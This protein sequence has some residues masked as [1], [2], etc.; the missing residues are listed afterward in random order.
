V[1]RWARVLA[2]EPPY[3]FVISW[4]ISPTWQLVDDPSHA[5]EVES[6]LCL[7]ARIEPESSWST[8]ISSVTARAGARCV[9]ASGTRVGWP[10]YVQRYVDAV[11]ARHIK[12]LDG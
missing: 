8:V 9:T 6:H 2:F 10:F 11:A 5:S 3:R 12:G 1:F 4:D 7:R